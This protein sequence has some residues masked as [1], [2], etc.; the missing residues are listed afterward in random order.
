MLITCWNPTYPSFNQPQPVLVLRDKIGWAESPNSLQF[1]FK[2]GYFATKL[3]QFPERAKKSNIILLQKN[4]IKN[5]HFVWTWLWLEMIVRGWV[6]TCWGFRQAN[7]CG[8]D[9]HWLTFLFTIPRLY[10]F[11]FGIAESAYCHG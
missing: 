8:V 9:F 11:S 5:S 7:K 10:I 3:Q 6:F 4:F 1:G 2:W